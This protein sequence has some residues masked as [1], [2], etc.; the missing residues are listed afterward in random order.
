[1]IYII[2]ILNIDINI[3]KDIN[4]NRYKDF[5][6]TF[7][8]FFNSA[9]TVTIATPLIVYSAWLIGEIKI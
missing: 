8:F 1:M 7:R 6:P 2:K 3:L 4:L 5:D 9:N